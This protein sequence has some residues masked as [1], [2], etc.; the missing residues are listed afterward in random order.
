MDSIVRSYLDSFCGKFNIDKNLSESKR[1]EY[2]SIFSILS[3]EINSNL[4]KN[5]LESIILPDGTRGIDGISVTINDALI[6]NADEIDNFKDQRFSVS[7]HFFQVKISESFSDSEVGSFL[8]TIIDFFSEEPKY[9]IQIDEY[10][11]YLE[12]YK[13]LLQIISS[14]KEVNLFCYYISLGQKQESNTT[15]DCTVKNKSSYLEKYN[16]FTNTH[17]Q[18]IDKATLISKHKKAISPLKSEFKFENKISLSGI[19]SIEEAYIGY[20]SFSEFKKL[21]IDNENNKIKSLFN[22]NLRDF[23]GFDNPI[24]QNIKQTLENRKFSE[25][26]LLNNGITVIAE[27]NSGRGNTLVLENYQIVNGCQTSNVLYECRNIEGIDNVLIPLKVIITKDENLRDEI[28]ITT[29]SQS[30]FTEEQ[31]FAI[32]QFQKE[33]EDYYISQKDIDGIYYER[34]TNQY[35]N[36]NKSKIVDIKEQLKSFMAMF[37]DVPHLVS[38]NIGK[39]I[40]QYKDKFFQ[41]DHSPIPYYISGLLSKKWDELIQSESNYKEFNKFRYHIFMGF[42]YLV[43]DLPFDQR[44]LSKSNI[45]QYAIKSENQRINSYEKLLQVLRDR[46]EVKRNLDNSIEIFKKV[47]Y[48]RQKAAYSGPITEEYKQ[49]IQGYLSQ[50]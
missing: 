43:E 36:I 42:R 2:F 11:S 45:K 20:V 17:I 50:N 28:I 33:L 25:F 23:L 10:S 31:L 38:G 47:D 15:I 41:K 29:N 48:T 13:R 22:D 37:F 1:F 32:T 26:S 44:Y 18:L 6:F 40:K 16:F 19:P 3:D 21:I 39:V 46:Q 24:N 35:Q 12:I 5:D 49:K 9:N 4:D 27:S 30:S 7:F 8:D 34:R 14:L